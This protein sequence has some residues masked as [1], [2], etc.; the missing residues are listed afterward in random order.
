M[1]VWIL[2]GGWKSCDE[3]CVVGVFLSSEKA[4]KRMQETD[5][6]NNYDFYWVSEHTV[7]E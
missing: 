2:F 3:Q 1:K 4:E 5:S 7:E 6:L